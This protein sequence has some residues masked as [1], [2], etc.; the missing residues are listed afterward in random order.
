MFLFRYRQPTLS[1]DNIYF[2]NFKYPRL[3]NRLYQLQHYVQNWRAYLTH[4]EPERVDSHHRRPL[5]SLLQRSHGSASSS[6]STTNPSFPFPLFYSRQTP[7]CSCL[8][9]VPRD[10]IG[11]AASLFSPCLLKIYEKQTLPV[12]ILLY[13]GVEVELGLDSTFQTML[14]YSFLQMPTTNTSSLK[15]AGRVILVIRLSSMKC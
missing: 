14:V 13:S 4:A 3:V 5:L 15:S 12:V 9:I 7:C 6:L 2:K 10:T 8:S 1:E 11:S